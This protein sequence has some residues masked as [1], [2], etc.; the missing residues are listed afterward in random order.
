MS[1][2][3]IDHHTNQCAVSGLL[4]YDRDGAR[5]SRIEGDRT[6]V[7]IG[8][9]IGI[10]HDVTVTDAKNVHLPIRLIV[11]KDPAVRESCALAYNR[12]SDGLDV[13]RLHAAYIV[14]VKRALGL[15]VLAPH[16]RREE[17]LVV[18]RAGNRMYAAGI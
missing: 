3:A 16:Q 2:K 4:G 1:R 9:K 10:H 11:L 6:M 18:S 5:E 15:R 12:I 14:D 8:L 13:P 17:P 7:I